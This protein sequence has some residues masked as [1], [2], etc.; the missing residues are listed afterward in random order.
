LLLNISYRP[1]EVAKQCSTR[2]AQKQESVG[3]VRRVISTK[4]ETAI[5]ED[6]DD[7]GN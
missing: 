7:I 4:Y 3:A 5:R 1:V 2:P 6:D